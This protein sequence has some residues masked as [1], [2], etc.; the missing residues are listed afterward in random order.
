VPYKQVFVRT[1]PSSAV[2]SRDLGDLLELLPDGRLNIRLAATP[3]VIDIGVHESIQ[4]TVVMAGDQPFQE[5][6]TPDKRFRLAIET[7]LHQDVTEFWLIHTDK[8]NGKFKR[9]KLNTEWIK[10]RHALPRVAV[11]PHGS[12]FL[13]DDSGTVRLYG[14]AHMVDMGAFQVAH[15]NTENRIIA[16]AVST[17]ESLIAGLSSWKDIVLYSVM[18][19]RVA[20][21]RQIKDSVGWYDPGQAHILVT[22]NADAIVTVG[23][24]QKG[25][26]E[27]NLSVNA[28]RFVPLNAALSAA[29]R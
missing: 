20:F 1:Y 24:S 3:E 7:F 14:A 15:P 9:L 16:L 2:G 28:F 29:N 12:F 11:S 19:R 22:G 4:S 21:V 5:V 25:G 18:D 17:D 8:A 27:A 10:E 23:L 26:A 6:E 13:A